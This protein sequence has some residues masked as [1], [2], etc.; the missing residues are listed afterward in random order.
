MAGRST[1]LKN[2]RRIEGERY[3]CD[4]IQW[5]DSQPRPPQAT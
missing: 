5:S 2:V 3:E 1:A 4:Y